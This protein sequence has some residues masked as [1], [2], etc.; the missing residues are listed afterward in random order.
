MDKIRIEHFYLQYSDGNES[1]HDINLVIPANAITVLFGPAGGGKSSLLRSINRLNDLADVDRISGSIFLAD[2]FL[3]GEPEPSYIDVLKPETNVITLR[4]R[5]SMVFAQP[6]VLPLSIRGNLTYGLEMAGI[7]DK[8]KLEGAVETS[9]KKAALW[10]EVH[11]RLDDSAFALS[12]G[13]Q[14]RL[15]LARCLALEPEVILLD[16]PTS[17]LDPISTHKVEASLQELK[18]QYT[19]ILVPH[20]I[21]QAARTSDYCAFFLQGEMVEYLPGKNI[22]TN[23]KDKRT[24]DYVEGRFG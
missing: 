8:E 6:I 24:E 15:C 7:H 10:E 14:Q 19:I 13:Q 5:V 3:Q 9:L 1:L 23:P 20:S 11:H 22:F 4:R 18:E 12:G 21:Q 16:E 17:G 2:K